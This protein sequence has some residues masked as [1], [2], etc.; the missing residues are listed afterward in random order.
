MRVTLNQF[1]QTLDR[2]GYDYDYWNPGDCTI[3]VTGEHGCV[4]IPIDN[5]AD[6]SMTIQVPGKNPHGLILWAKQL[7]RKILQEYGTA[8]I[9]LPK[10]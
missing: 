10:D 4:H 3:V 6:T 9:V 7:G 8:E 5:V 1:Y 2:W